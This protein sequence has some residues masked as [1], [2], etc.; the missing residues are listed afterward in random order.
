MRRPPLVEMLRWPSETRQA[1]RRGHR[2]GRSQPGRSMAPRGS[3][4]SDAPDL[5]RQIRP[6]AELAEADRRPRPARQA[7]CGSE[8]EGFW[9]VW[10]GSCLPDG[11]ERT[12]RRGCRVMPLL[13]RGLITWDD[14]GCAHK[15]AAHK[16]ICSPG[17][18]I[19]ATD[20]V[21]A[22]VRGLATGPYPDSQHGLGGY[23]H[24]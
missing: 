14:Q 24:A 18:E 4:A 15:M 9:R 2:T 19:Q 8:G 13:R 10:V 16:R 7:C 11:G 20:S 6:Q 5:L 3:G 12:I 23:E 21:R 22:S 1:M 17:C